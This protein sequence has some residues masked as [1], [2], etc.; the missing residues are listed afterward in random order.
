MWTSRDREGAV[1]HRRPSGPL[2][3]GR[4]SFRSAIVPEA[5]ATTPTAEPFCRPPA[6][7]WAAMA[8]AHFDRDDQDAARASLRE[9]LGL[10]V[11][12][13]VVL[14]GHQA[15]LWHSGILAKRFA[16]TAL[17]ALAPAAGAW[18]VVD[19]DAEDAGA[20]RVPVRTPDRPGGIEARAI[21]LAP[22]DPARPLGHRPAIGDLAPIE[23]AIAQGLGEL[24]PGRLEAVAAA[25]RAHADA[26]SLADQ[27]AR[28]GEDLLPPEEPRVP[29]LSSLAIA[30]TTLFRNVVE[31]MRGDAEACRASYNR[32]IERVGPGPGIRPLAPGELP[33]WLLRDG[34]R[35]PA[36]VERLAERTER[37]GLAPRGLLMTGVLRH[38]ACDLFIHGTG[39]GGSAG[40]RPGYDRVTE[41]WLADWL[42]WDGLAPVVVATATLELP[43]P[44]EPVPSER[45]LAQA[46]WLAHH[47]AHEPDLLGDGSASARKRALVAQ[48]QASVDAEERAARFREMHEL[49]DRARRAHAA[50][51]QGMARAAEGVRA[52]RAAGGLRTDRTWSFAL[53][54]APAIASLR[55]ST[56]A[57]FVRGR[58]GADAS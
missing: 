13:P 25:L 18:L 37:D 23:R 40:S 48:I 19:H 12:R 9:E 43:L 53:H 4:G 57:A 34:R 20:L 33:L 35:L 49:L 7:S 56:H 15:G 36:T 55:A 29:L 54:P 1:W 46:R 45:E 11:D 17:A 2:P 50:R 6:S 51:L 24:I 41:R 44:G 8:R 47:A 27:L 39:G 26:P 5:Q 30:R 3:H 38:A 21:R 31:R 58:D 16:L 14:S 28:A 10:P 32:A 22:D 52:R 42:G